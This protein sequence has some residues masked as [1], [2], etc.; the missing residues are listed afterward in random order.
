MLLICNRCGTKYSVGAPYCPQCTSTDFREEGDDVPKISKEDGPSNAGADPVL[1]PQDTDVEQPASS[2]EPVDGEGT[3]PY[4]EVPDGSVETV[5]E[6]VGDDED[7]ASAALQVEQDKSTPRVTLIN[8]LE[9]KL[10]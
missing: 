9:A 4:G 7:R 2:T 8:A 6:W 3:P 5:L 1:L 10:V